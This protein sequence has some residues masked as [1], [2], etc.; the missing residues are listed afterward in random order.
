MHL[1]LASVAKL[2][3]PGGVLPVG[4]LDPQ[5]PLAVLLLKYGCIGRWSAIGNITVT[6]TR[7]CNG[8]S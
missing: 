6:A 3:G 8:D 4:D 2:A 7:V 1:E 5:A